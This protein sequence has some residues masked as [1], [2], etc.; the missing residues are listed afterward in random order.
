MR[1]VHPE[2]YRKNMKSIYGLF[3]LIL[4]V[5]GIIGYF[6]K[7][8]YNFPEIPTMEVVFFTSVLLHFA[9]VQIVFGKRMKEFNDSKN[10]KP[11]GNIPG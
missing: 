5:N 10:K 3:A 1:K 7:R 8:Y 4:L 2:F 9:A 11:T 6:I